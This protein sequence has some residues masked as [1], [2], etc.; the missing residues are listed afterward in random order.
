M[1]GLQTFVLDSQQGQTQ[2]SQI[3]V[4]RCTP[5]Q[6]ANLGILFASHSAVLSLPRTIMDFF[7]SSAPHTLL[8]LGSRSAVPYKETLLGS[9]SVAW[10]P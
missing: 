5:N 4:V 10:S 1:I 9:P 7:S 8:P 3:F 2:F 6:P